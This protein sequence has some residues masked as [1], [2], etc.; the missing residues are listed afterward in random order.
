MAL[1]KLNDVGDACAAVNLASSPMAHEHYTI[2]TRVKMPTPQLVAGS[3]PRL[4]HA[5]PLVIRDE[6]GKGP[7]NAI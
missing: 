6:Y 3:V 4:R 5:S 2:G 1:A 7:G